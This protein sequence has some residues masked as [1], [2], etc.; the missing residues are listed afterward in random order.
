[1]K[2][3]KYIKDNNLDSENMH[4]TENEKIFLYHVKNKE[5]IEMLREDWALTFEGLSLDLQNIEAVLDWIQ[6]YTEFCN[7][8]FYVLY[9]TSGKLM[10]KSYNLTGTKAYPDDLNIVSVKLAD[11]ENPNALAVSKFDVR[12]RWM[13]D[14]IANNLE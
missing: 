8:S 2:I 9:V 10:D 14:V 7:K 1:M 6:H 11:L 12:A 5:E 4:S 3:E 13:Y